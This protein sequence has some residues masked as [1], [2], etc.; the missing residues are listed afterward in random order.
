MDNAKDFYLK[1]L[2]ILKRL[3]GQI[4][5]AQAVLAEVTDHEDTAP[6]ADFSDFYTL[7]LSLDEAFLD[8]GVLVDSVEA[9]V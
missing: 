6:A 8:A 3:K 9:M 7:Q 5:A 4:A 2:A 1:K